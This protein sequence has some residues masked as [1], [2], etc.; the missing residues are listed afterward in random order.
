MMFRSIWALHM[1][2]EHLSSKSGPKGQRPR[3]LTSATLKL[4]TKHVQFDPI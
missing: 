2:S 1:V 4:Q 3:M